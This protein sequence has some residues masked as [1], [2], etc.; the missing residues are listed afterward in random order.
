MRPDQVATIARRLGVGEQEHHLGAAG[1]PQAHLVAVNQDPLGQVARQVSVDEQIEIW[2]RPLHDGTIG[3]AIFNRGTEA[4]KWAL[5]W[6]DVGL[7]GPQ[8]VRDLWQQK[9]LG[10]ID[11]SYGGTIPPH[12]SMLLK[13]GTPKE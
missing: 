9:D 11:A 4:G 5:R 13:L 8:P 1:P 6:S 7:A 10:K 12:G 3:V 2:S